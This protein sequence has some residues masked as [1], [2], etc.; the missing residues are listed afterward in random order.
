MILNRSLP[1]FNNINFY[2]RLFF[3]PK[4]LPKQTKYI[5]F[6]VI[7]CSPFHLDE[8]ETFVCF[9]S[10]IVWQETTIMVDATNYYTHTTMSINEGYKM[11]HP[12]SKFIRITITFDI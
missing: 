1:K 5:H 10:D 6:I 7:K 9:F 2:V 12:L 4:W 3:S 11:G 8:D